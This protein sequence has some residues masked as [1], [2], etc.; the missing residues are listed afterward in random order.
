MQLLSWISVTAAC[1]RYPG[2]FVPNVWFQRFAPAT[3]SNSA[4][5]N[6]GEGG[7]VITP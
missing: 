7:K 2:W 6:F 4:S 3:A 1:R 5:V